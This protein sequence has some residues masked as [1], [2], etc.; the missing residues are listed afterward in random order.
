MSQNGPRTVLVVDDV[1]ET[2]WSWP[3]S[4]AANIA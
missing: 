4:Y 2:S 1:P 3:A